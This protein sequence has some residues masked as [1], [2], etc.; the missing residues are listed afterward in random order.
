MGGGILAAIAIAVVAFLALGGDD[1]ESIET[2]L[3]ASFARDTGAS[4]E[5]AACVARLLV[6]EAGEDAFKD[7]DF[8]ASDPPP[9]VVTALLAM[10]P[11]KLMDECGIDEEAFG[12]TDGS[13]DGST[14]E[15]TDT[16]ADASTDG[17]TDGITDSSAL[18]EG[19]DEETL[20]DTYE[21]MLGLRPDQAECLAGKL[22]D[23]IESGELNEEQV[24][25]EFFDYLSDCDISMEEISGN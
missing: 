15:S 10:E 16:S 1:D 3:A 19:F 11:E 23:A 24:T 22:K 4:D 2:Q 17:F 18:P 25:S 14:D 21:Q 7:T 20:A 8:S 13:T 6:D 12:G 5:E 9:E